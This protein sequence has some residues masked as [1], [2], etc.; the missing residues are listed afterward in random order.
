LVARIRAG[1]VDAFE[2]LMVL[3]ERQVLATACRLLGHLDDAQDAA[4]EVFLRLYKYLVRFDEARELS[5]WLYRVTVNVCR[6]MARKRPKPAVLSLEDIAVE[7][8]PDPVDSDAI[9]V[10]LQ[11]KQIVAHGLKLLPEKERAAVVLRDMEGLSTKEVARIL[12]STEMTVRSQ[13]S[14]ARVKMKRFIEGFL[15][16]NRPCANARHEE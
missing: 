10:L 4:Q 7:D 6:D 8:I 9:M 3:H 13:V 2:E 15:R 5:P 14:R 11:H 12:G 16:R 1:D